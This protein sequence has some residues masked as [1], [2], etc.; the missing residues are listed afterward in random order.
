ME[1]TSYCSF[2]SSF[3]WWCWL[4]ENGRRIFLGTKYVDS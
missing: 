1:R 4:A 3:T 2:S